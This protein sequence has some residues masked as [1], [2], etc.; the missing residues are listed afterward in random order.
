MSYAADIAACTANLNEIKAVLA[1]QGDTKWT[2]AL[3]QY[4][5]TMKTLLDAIDARLTAGML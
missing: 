3:T 1:V 5:D 4:C 2:A